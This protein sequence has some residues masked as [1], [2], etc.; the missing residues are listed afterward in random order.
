M[1]TPSLALAGELATL[2]VEGPDLRGRVA[3][4][5]AKA[6]AVVAESRCVPV[7]PHALLAPP[8]PV[9][10]PPPAPPVAAPPPVAVTNPLAAYLWS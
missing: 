3:L 6:R 8:P 5:V 2:D 10:A 1:A 9:A 4:L 7:P